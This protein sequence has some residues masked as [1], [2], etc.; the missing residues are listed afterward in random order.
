[1]NSGGSDYTVQKSSPHKCG[2]KSCCSAFNVVVAVFPLDIFVFLSSPYV[3]EVYPHR[4]RLLDDHLSH[5][6]TCLID[7]RPVRGG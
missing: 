3:P 1:M 7:I 2:Q 4:R 5:P 6:G